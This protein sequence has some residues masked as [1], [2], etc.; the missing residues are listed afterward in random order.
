MKNSV[1]VGEISVQMGKFLHKW[2]NFSTN[3]KIEKDTRM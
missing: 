2:E 1:Q 3:G